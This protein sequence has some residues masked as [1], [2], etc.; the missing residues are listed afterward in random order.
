MMGLRPPPYFT[1][2]SAYYAE[3]VV[4][5]ERRDKKNPFHWETI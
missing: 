3:E 2:Q 5:G 4:Q 1:G